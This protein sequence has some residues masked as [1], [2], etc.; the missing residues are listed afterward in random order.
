MAE[1]KD[2]FF[3]GIRQWTLVGYFT[4]EAGMTQA[5]RYDPIPGQIEPCVEVNGDTRAEAQY[6]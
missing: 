2:A 5:L 4:S 3:I 6:F 1:G